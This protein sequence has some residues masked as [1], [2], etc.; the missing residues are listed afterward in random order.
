MSTAVTAG[1]G[2]VFWII[3]AHAYTHQEI[4]I[5]SAVI[6][7][8]STVSLLTYLGPAAMLIERLPE[9]EYTSAW[10][11]FLFRMCVATACVTL[12]V[13]A[14]TV[15]LLLAS[16]NYHLFYSGLLPVLLVL[17]GAPAWTIVNLLSGACVAARRSGRFLSIQALVS[18]A[19]LLF[20]LP[21]AA[22]ATGAAGLVAA[23]VASAVIGVG[24]GGIWLIPQ[25]RLG[26]R[27]GRHQRR[28]LRT[29]LPGRRY[30]A[31]RRHPQGYHW[32]SNRAFMQRLLFHHLTSVGGAVT[33]LV[34][35]V[36]V[37]F[38]LGATGNAYFYIT[39][40]IGGI[41]FTVSPSVASALFAE[42]V[43]AHADLSS[44][45]AK[46]LRVIAVVLTPVMIVVIA[47][48]RLILD[49]FGPSYAAAG[50]GLLV[51]LAISALP[52]A[53]SNVAVAVLRVTKRVGYSSV[54]NL[55]ILVV[56]LASAWVLMPVLGIF[57][58][59]VAWLGAQML[60]AIA[61]V[62][63]FT[64]LRGLALL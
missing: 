21:L 39:W 12:V 46:A 59:G 47:G 33:P 38:R 10:S 15:P 2:Y 41:F 22:A 28:G 14:V 42:G 1:L 55:G 4:G 32:S 53:F 20:L 7:L 45:A 40:M 9:K 48:G 31:K 16:K 17:L 13:I 26:R 51:L 61:S 52:D 62:P 49:L 24:I 34:L 57:G 56:A 30:R 8:C 50:Y 19:K 25:M 29:L 11:T 60:G 54:L 63:A 5:G 44:V 3:A 23:W 18:G 37:V 35:P 27:P 64:H 36:L 6:A 43:R 58:V